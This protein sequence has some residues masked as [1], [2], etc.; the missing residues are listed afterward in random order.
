MPKKTSNSRKRRS[1]HRT[2]KRN[3]AVI[4]SGLL[5]VILITAFF[6]NRVLKLYPDLIESDRNRTE[7]TL[8]PN[9]SA[10]TEL[11]DKEGVKNDSGADVLDRF[12][13]MIAEANK[14]ESPST[15][16]SGY[17]IPQLDFKA[18]GSHSKLIALAG[19]SPKEPSRSLRN[20]GFQRVATEIMVLSDDGLLLHIDGFAMKNSAGIQII[21]QA[22]APYG[23]AYRVSSTQSDEIPFSQPVSLIHLILIDQNGEG[24]SD[25]ITLYWHPSSNS[26]KATN[27][28]GAPGTY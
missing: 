15:I 4:G 10:V 17:V 8:R 2:N 11:P 9:D 19:I 1:L 13:S 23:Y 14:H 12:E 7:S 28:F 20:Y 22:P 18:D 26:F 16:P 27:T 6:V 3:A 25:E 21:E 24:I 5:I